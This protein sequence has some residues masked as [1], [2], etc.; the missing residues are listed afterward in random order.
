MADVTKT[1]LATFE[2]GQRFSVSGPDILLGPRATLSYSLL[3]HELGTNALKYGSLSVPEGRVEI[4]W[5]L[6][7]DA[8]EQTLEL[9]WR[10]VGGPPVV[11]PTGRGFGSRLIRM[12]L[13]GTGGVQLDYGTDGLT[14]TMRAPLSQVQQS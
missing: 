11:E 4:D 1:V 12:G 8:D 14:A 10:E 5:R 2:G 13:I 7:R 9:S 3:L 6:L